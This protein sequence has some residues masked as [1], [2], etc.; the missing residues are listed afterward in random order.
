[1]RLVLVNP[2]QP[3]LIEKQ[4]Q[5]PLGL[6]YLAAVLKRDCPKIDLKV[7]DTSPMS[8]TEAVEAVGEADIY[9]FTSTSLDYHTVQELKE[10]LS[11]HHPASIFILGGPHAA[12]FSKDVLKEGFDHVEAL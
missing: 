1:M 6:L 10:A 12:I 9:G 2:P 11:A 3:Y 7:V 4:T 5:V 8:I